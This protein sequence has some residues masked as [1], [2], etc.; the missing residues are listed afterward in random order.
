MKTIIE[1]RELKVTWNTEE[2]E[3]QYGFNKLFICTVKLVN[4][5]TMTENP[6]LLAVN[7]R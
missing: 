4:N 3:F 7:R 6:L 1:L 2:P 5:C